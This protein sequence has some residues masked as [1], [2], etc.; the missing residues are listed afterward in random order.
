MGLGD[1]FKKVDKTI[2]AQNIFNTLC[3]GYSFSPKVQMEINDITKQC[4]SRQDILDKVIELCN[5]PN[6][7]HKRYLT[8][9]AYSWSVA[10]YRQEAIF[11]IKQYLDGALYE[12]AYNNISHG[13]VCC[14][15]VSEEDI[16]LSNMYRDLGRA[17]E[18][19]YDFEK[20][21][22]AYS[23]SVKLTPYYAHTYCNLARVLTK[24]NNIA[25]AKEV[26]EKSKKTIYYE[27]FTIKTQL[28]KSYVDDGFKK[29]IDSSLSEVVEKINKGY[30]YRP[31]RK[32]KQ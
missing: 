15:P 26:F 17:Y 32:K 19:E 3:V 30:V 16:H 9:M 18:G 2:L 12:A 29:V 5:P 23:E 21:Y 8:A 4:S 6:T 14:H 28:G 11:S 13:T 1:I 24:M 7:P 10:K 22:Q 25:A 27:P 31:R 20:A